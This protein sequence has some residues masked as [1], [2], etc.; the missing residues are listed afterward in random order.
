MI[1]YV[2]MW[3][4]FLPDIQGVS[5]CPGREFIGNKDGGYINSPNYPLNYGNNMNCMF[6]LVV[7]TG[8]KTHIEFLE[9]KIECKCLSDW[10]INFQKI[11]YRGG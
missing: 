2:M 7:P 5:V 6:T 1:N 11:I 9:M 8:K 4:S 10:V 3:F